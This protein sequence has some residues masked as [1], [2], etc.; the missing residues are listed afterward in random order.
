MYEKQI[1]LSAYCT[2]C[3][4]EVMRETDMSP[5]HF[6]YSFGRFIE[7]YFYNDGKLRMSECG[8]KAL[9]DVVRKYVVN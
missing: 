2:I 5:M 8:H 6:E 9:R 3:R 7:Q 4:K 1:F